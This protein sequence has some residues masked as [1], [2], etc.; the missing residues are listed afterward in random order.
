MNVAPE[1]VPPADMKEFVKGMMM[2]GILAD[3]SFPMGSDNGF[4]H[5]AG[6]GFSG[7]LEFSYFV[8]PMFRIMFRGGYINFG[9]QT[10]SGSEDFGFGQTFDYNYEDTYS[11]IPI[12]IGGYYMFATE[13]GFKPYIGLAIG[14]F[15]ET[16]AV[17]WNGRFRFWR[18]FYFD[19]SFTSTGF[20]V[21]PAIGA[22]YSLDQY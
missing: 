21:V 12:L 10:N 16:Y 2:L 3:V 22:Y 9:K 7:H 13:S 1:V 4:G 14:V 11:Q 5:I 20:G 8:S 6:T 17:N 18:T 15:F 19:E